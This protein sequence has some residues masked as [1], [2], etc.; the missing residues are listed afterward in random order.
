MWLPIEGTSQPPPCQ[1]VQS[2]A[3]DE[4][5]S[6]TSLIFSSPEQL[7]REAEPHKPPINATEK[8]LRKAV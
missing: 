4:S 6:Q 2:G 7:R 3:Q 1:V 5:L 8:D